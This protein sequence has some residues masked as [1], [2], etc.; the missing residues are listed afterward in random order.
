MFYHCLFQKFLSDIEL[1]EAHVHKLLA[2]HD[3]LRSSAGEFR[4]TD[5]HPLEAEIAE[6]QVAA[7]DRRDAL[8]AAI[9]QQGVYEEE[10]VEL[11]EK[12][13]S[14]QAQLMAAPVLSS[15]L[16]GLQQQFAEL[17]VGQMLLTPQQTYDIGPMAGRCWLLLPSIWPVLGQ[18][19]MLIGT[20]RLLTT[21]HS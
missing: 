16:L 10:V 15:S 8:K 21:H 11:Q 12:I 4:P 19:W 3:D 6:L 18:C 5:G 14:S 13:E 20:C 1:H 9:A 7:S 2:A 17:N